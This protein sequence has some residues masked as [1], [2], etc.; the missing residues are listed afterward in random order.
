MPPSPAPPTL[1]GASA[2]AGAAALLD[3][4]TGWQDQ[5][6]APARREAG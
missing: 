6:A 2:A 4:L 3:A 1:A 5:S